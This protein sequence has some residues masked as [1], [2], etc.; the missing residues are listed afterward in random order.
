MKTCAAFPYINGDL[1]AE[2]L[3]VPSFTKAMRA[4]LLRACDFNWDAISPAIFGALFQSVM[5]E[6]ASA[7]A[8]GALHDRAQH[9][10]S[11]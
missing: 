2:R 4:L 5:D 1:F 6:A 3:R 11:D 9:P 8:G 10:E 7:G